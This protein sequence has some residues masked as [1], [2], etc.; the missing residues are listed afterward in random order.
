MTGA[1]RCTVLIAEDHAVARSGLR[2][3]LGREPGFEIVASAGDGETALALAREHAPDV[4]ILDLMLP[5]MGGA[6]VL[7]ALARQDVRPRVLIL[8]GQLDGHECEALLASGA[9]AI[10]SKEDPAEE[11]IEALRAVQR[12]ETYLSTTVRA[13]LEPLEGGDP[14]D[15]TR[16]TPRER[17]VLGLVAEGYSSEEIGLRLGIATKTVKKHRENIREKLGISTVAEAMRAAVRLG[18]AK[19]S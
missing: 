1:D 17:E 18:L 10:A 8:S 6:L 2:F 12:G 4:L 11:L 3:L 5:R 15:R 9:A 14:R 13:L 7:Q 19:L 16:L